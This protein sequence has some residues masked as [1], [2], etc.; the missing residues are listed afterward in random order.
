MKTKTKDTLQGILD[1]ITTVQDQHNLSDENLYKAASDETR[2]E[3]FLKMFQL[4][5]QIHKD[6]FPNLYETGE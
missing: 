6:I 5:K 2:E 1:E 3:Y 4:L